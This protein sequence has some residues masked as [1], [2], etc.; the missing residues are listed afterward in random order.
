[1]LSGKPSPNRKISS[2][3]TIQYRAAELLVLEASR[4]VA[5]VDVQVAVR[6]VVEVDAVGEAEADVVVA[7][8]DAVEVGEA[9]NS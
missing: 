8:V 5:A 3:I 6:V 7:A 4:A 9:I 1:M 2:L